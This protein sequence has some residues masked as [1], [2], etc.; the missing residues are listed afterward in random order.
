MMQI[1][2]DPRWQDPIID[3]LVNENLPKDKF[4]ARKIKQKNAR[5][6]MKN[7]MLVHKS[8]SSPYLTYI[9]YP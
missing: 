2:E 6:Y 9:K 1:D 3:Y 4:E 8:Y 7:N 5:Y